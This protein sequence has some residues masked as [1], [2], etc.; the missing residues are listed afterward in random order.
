MNEIVVFGSINIDFSIE[1]DRVP[2]IG[3]TINGTNLKVSYGGKGNNQAFAANKLGGK[4]TLI[5][6]VGD[7]LYGKEIINHLKENNVDTDYIYVDKEMSTGQAFIT[8]EKGNN[9]IIV[10]KGANDK[11]LANQL[12][13]LLSN[14]TVTGDYFVTQ[15]ENNLD[16]IYSAIK[17]A[18]SNN[19]ITIL[20]PS[21]F[22]QIDNEIFKYVDYLIL[23]EIELE[24]ITGINDF[25]KAIDKIKHLG[26]KNI[27]LTLGKDGSIC[28][29]D[30]KKISIKPYKI[31]SVDSTGAGDTYLGA[32]VYSLSIGKD[33]VD[34]ANFASAASAL[35]CLKVGAQS[36][37]PSYEE[38][39]EFINKY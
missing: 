24:M 27:I 4:V 8:R 34:S 7:D 37:M 17:L 30:D 15:F 38:V 35:K 3:E 2:K 6:A 13:K 14:R 25:T 18:K 20:N 31:S 12:I 9:S 5:G 33:I 21:P 1:V 26:C 10:Y 28:F 19:M 39:I 11:L 29:V 36:G 32:F 16:E 22:Q 23:N